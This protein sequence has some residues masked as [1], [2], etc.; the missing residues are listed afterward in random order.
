MRARTCAAALLLLAV[1]GGCSDATKDD[2]QTPPPAGVDVSPGGEGR[3]GNTGGP[4]DVKVPDPCTLV[5][6]QEAT[7]ALGVATDAT[8]IPAGGGLPGQRSCGYADSASAKLVQVAV[9]PADAAAF[10]A[11][12]GQAGGTAQDV[13][14][15]GDAAFLAAGTLYVHKGSL[16]VSVFAQGLG[17]DAAAKPVLTSLATAAVGRL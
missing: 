7:T 1:L 4:S 2:A 15:L 13:S 6:Q 17:T 16:A 3:A 11:L 12:K 10:T 8:A 9:W 14:G 5:T